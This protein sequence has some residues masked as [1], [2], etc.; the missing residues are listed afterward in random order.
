MCGIQGGLRYDI[1]IIGSLRLPMQGG[2]RYYTVIIGSLRLQKI[3]TQTRPEK[4]GPRHGA[5]AA[6]SP[7]QKPTPTPAQKER[8]PSTASSPPRGLQKKKRLLTFVLVTQPTFGQQ[9][10]TKLLGLREISSWVGICDTR[11]QGPLAQWLSL[12]F[13]TPEGAWPLSQS[14]WV[15]R[16]GRGH[17]FGK[18]KGGFLTPPTLLAWWECIGRFFTQAPSSGDGCRV[19]RRARDLGNSASS[20]SLARLCFGFWCCSAP[21]LPPSSSSSPLPPP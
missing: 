14:T 2:L 1:V 5:K 17:G 8:R 13:G 12:P 20:H 6:V 21:P 18:G 11:G 16:W 7:R 9:E 3:N 19:R 10:Q 4:S 15:Q